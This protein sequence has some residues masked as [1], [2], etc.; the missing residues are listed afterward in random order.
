VRTLD[1]IEG[2][3]QIASS[4][5]DPARDSSASMRSPMPGAIKCSRVQASL[6]AMFWAM[7]GYPARCAS[8]K[9]SSSI[10]IAS[11]MRPVSINANATHDFAHTRSNSA[12][13]AV[14]TST[15]FVAVS[16]LWALSNSNL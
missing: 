11:A 3:E 2:S 7:N 9:H 16:R 15:A 6:Y 1:G 10:S 4:P 8:S 14:A 13:A 5:A 12:P